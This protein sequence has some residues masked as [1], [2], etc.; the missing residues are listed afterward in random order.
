MG[1]DRV[2]RSIFSG[3]LGKGVFRRRGLERLWRSEVKKQF[4]K[5]RSLER[6]FLGGLEGEWD[7]E[8]TMWIGFAGGFGAWF[9]QEWE[10]LRAIY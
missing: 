1:C 9:F 8:I 2:E 3:D 5:I 7:A 6:F 10:F 4:R